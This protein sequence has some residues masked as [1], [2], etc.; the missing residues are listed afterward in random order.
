[1]S[2]LSTTTG[3]NS[4][5]PFAFDG[6]QSASKAA[7]VP[8]EPLWI[9]ASDNVGLAV[10]VYEPST[11]RS[12]V[13]QP[14]TPTAVVI[15]NHGGGAHSGAGYQLLARGLADDFNAVV[16]TPDLRGHGAS[17]YPRG[18]APSS[19]QVFQDVTTVIDFVVKQH[20]QNDATDAAA[21][22]IF[23]GGH[24]SGG[25]LVLNYATWAKRNVANLSGYILVSPQLGYLAKVDR[26]PAPAFA[27]VNIPAFIVN[28]ISSGYFWGHYHAVQFQ[29]PPE[30]LENDPGMVRSNTINMANAITPTS[31][32]A[33]FEELGMATKDG[34]PL[35]LPLGLWIGEHDE[36]FLADKV[37]AY[38]DG[39]NNMTSA[40]LPDATHLGILINA[41]KTIGPWMAAQVQKAKH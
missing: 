21:L 40:I 24:S 16:Y 35:G 28:G 9:Q 11:L 36:M 20:H 33:Q 13:Q 15:F 3:T 25:G 23:L 29:Y 26:N 6:L 37:I 32:T 22:P 18:D 2:T 30:V 10:R 31:P 7:P 1:M 5:P 4:E 39:K 14:I 34:T 38:A 27:K 12:T 19:E 17:G 41:H 8:P